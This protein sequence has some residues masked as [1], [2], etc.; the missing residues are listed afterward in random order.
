[1]FQVQGLSFNTRVFSTTFFFSSRLYTSSSII[2]RPCT[3]T[4]VAEINVLDGDSSQRSL[5]RGLELV[6]FSALYSNVSTTFT[7]YRRTKINI[8]EQKVNNFDTE[9][10]ID[11]V[12][13]RLLI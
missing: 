8:R 7:R 4:R 10:F 1:M 6:S 9:L 2:V 11:E 12:G 13:K 5:K 3:H